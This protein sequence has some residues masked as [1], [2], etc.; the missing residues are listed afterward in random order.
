M[1]STFKHGYGLSADRTARPKLKLAVELLCGA[2]V[3]FFCIVA[4]FPWVLKWRSVVLVAVSTLVIVCTL[5]LRHLSAAAP[6][7][8]VVSRTRRRVGVIAAFIGVFGLFLSMELGSLR[9]GI[10]GAVLFSIALVSFALVLFL[11]SQPFSMES[12]SSAMG[13][14]WAAPRIAFD[15]RELRLREAVFAKT[16]RILVLSILAAGLILAVV[17]NFDLLPTR[18]GHSAI[19]PAMLLSYLAFAGAALPTALLTWNESET[20]DAES[21]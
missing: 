19:L 21:E 13:A 9:V 15:E 17:N 14:F 7:P 10:P 16:C 6:S 20:V 3:G 18:P 4:F 5:V 8:R 11:G 12:S 2:A 1:T